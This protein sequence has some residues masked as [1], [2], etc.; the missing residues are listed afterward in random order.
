MNQNVTPGDTISYT[1]NYKN[2]SSSTLSNATINV[3]LPKGVTFKGSTQGMSTTDNTI[4]ATLGSLEKGAQGFINVQASVDSD[5]VSGNN[6]LATATLT[7][8][9]PSGATDSAVAY[10]M[11]TVNIMN[12]QGA[13][14]FGA[15]FFPSTL[16]GWILLL[17]III[18]LI[19]LA[20]HYS[21]MAR[22]MRNQNQTTTVFRQDTHSDAGHH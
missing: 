3:V 22:N 5:V 19:L 20:R 7:F 16:L 13:F 1:I 2:I 4:V 11:N 18:I 14:A 8:T 15:G 21:I 9:T 6:L 12:T 17:A 10:Y